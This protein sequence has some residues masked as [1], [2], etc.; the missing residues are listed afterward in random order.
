MLQAESAASSA[1]QTHT[2][3]REHDG[4]HVP[5]RIGLALLACLLC[6]PIGFAAVIFAV[7]ANVERAHM[8]STEPPETQ[9]PALSAEGVAGVG[10]GGIAGP[11]AAVGIGSESHHAASSR[12]AS[13][14][15]SVHLHSGAGGGGLHEGGF[16]HSNPHPHPHLLAT[17]ALLAGLKEKPHD[18]HRRRM[19]RLNRYAFLLASAGLLA[20]I[21]ILIAWGVILMYYLTRTKCPL[22][23]RQT[24]SD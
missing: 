17:D 13:H 19:G 20:G 21:L 14:R 11:A 6:A 16:P 2:S 9:S 7:L 23:A 12:A 3:T 18:V 1:S 15:T 8:T 24:W 4:Y 5:L 22:C 10:V